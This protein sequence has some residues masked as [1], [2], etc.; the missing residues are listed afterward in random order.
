MRITKFGHSCLLVEE[1]NARILLDPGSY[2]TLPELE[3]IDAILITHEHQDHFDVPSI[4]K[5]LENNPEA[6]IFTNS[7]IVA[8]LAAE[9][10]KALVLEDAQS[11]DVKGVR[12]E[13]FGTQH[14][15]IHPEIP[16]PKNTGYMVADKLFQ[17]GD[18]FFVPSKP[19]EI[20][21]LPVVAPWS[22][23]SEVVD[24]LQAIKPRVAFPIHDAFLKA[25]AHPFYKLPQMFAEKQ[26][27]QWVVLIEGEAIDV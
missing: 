23:I 12:V 20:L 26:N 24:C 16:R 7:D 18:S 22:K 4:K 9:N 17:P 2:S 11:T 13:G 25:G 14:A 19:V 3:N 1:G 8:K 6:R 5:V 21:A 15:L 10:I 27:T